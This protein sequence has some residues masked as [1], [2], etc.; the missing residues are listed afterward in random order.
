MNYC[1]DTSSFISAWVRHYPIHNFPRFWT[2]LEG[3][4]A[5]G[6]LC[7]PDEVKRE[8]EKKSDG[9]KGWVYDHKEMFVVPD[10]QVQ[11][12]VRNV[13]AEFPRLNMKLQGR[14]VADPFVVALAKQQNLV[15]ITEESHGGT[16][17][18]PRIP[19]VCNHYGVQCINLLML[20]QGENW[21]IS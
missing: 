4:A 11:T 3:L 2:L 19:V 6:R 8:I 10:L 9:L 17:D 21:I 12:L 16:R 5:E 1:M 13:L 20:I 15:V 14:N 18:R 7:S